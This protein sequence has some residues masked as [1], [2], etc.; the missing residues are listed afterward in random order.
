MKS[1]LPEHAWRK[2]YAFGVVIATATVIQ[3]C[4]SA[5]LGNVGQGAFD[6][7]NGRHARQAFEGITVHVNNNIM[8]MRAGY[9]SSTIIIYYSY[10]MQ[11]RRKMI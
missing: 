7:R 8:V 3:G 5:A 11:W 4:L 6:T 2:A 9:C 10:I 1:A